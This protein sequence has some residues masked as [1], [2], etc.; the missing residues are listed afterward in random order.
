MDERTPWWLWPARV[1]VVAIALAGIAWL[2]NQ[3][4]GRPSADGLLRLAWRTAGEQ[5]RL[6]RRRSA[7]ELNRLT[8]H[9]RQAEDCRSRTLPYR[10]QVRVDGALRVE[11][12][13]RSVGARGDRP[14]YVH[15]ELPLAPGTYRVEVSYRVAPELARG[16]DGIAVDTPEQAKAL[17]EALAAAADFHGQAQVQARAGRIVLVDLDESAGRFRVEGG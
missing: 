7:E 1:A 11:R 10:L 13:V 2:S 16:P 14:L 6:C 4:Y 5:V 12:A 8:Q 9:M 17:D 15:E 3:P